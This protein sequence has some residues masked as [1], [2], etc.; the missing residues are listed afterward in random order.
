V[1]N[2]SDWLIG[3]EYHFQQYASVLLMIYKFS[4]WYLQ[5]IISIIKRQAWY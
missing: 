3:V 1:N 4:L 5:T 2:N